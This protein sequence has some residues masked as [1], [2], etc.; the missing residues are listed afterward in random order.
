VNVAVTVVGALR[1]T[2]HVPTPLHP[3]P[4][5]PVKVEPASGVAVNVTVVPE[6]KLAEQVAPQLLIPAGELLTLP[7]P[8]PDSATVRA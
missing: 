4:L 6:V 7:V 3:P 5:Q 2:E 8:V 1:V